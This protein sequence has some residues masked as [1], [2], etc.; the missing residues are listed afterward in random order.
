MWIRSWAGLNV[1]KGVHAKCS[2]V[3][4]GRIAGSKFFIVVGQILHV[5]H[6]VTVIQLK[7]KHRQGVSKKRE[8]NRTIL[9]VC[10]EGN[11]RPASNNE[12]G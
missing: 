10:S 12:W 3:A 5:R 1:L 8:G 4:E 11:D 7:S 6:G 9:A 2:C